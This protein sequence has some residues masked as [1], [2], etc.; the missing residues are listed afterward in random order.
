[1]SNP[2][3]PQAES[4]AATP[5]PL[6]RVFVIG[7]NRIVEDTSTVK[8]SNEQI[9]S[10]L[11]AQYPEIANATVRETVEGE[12]RVIAYLPIPGRKG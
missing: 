4:A 7:N 8:L 6:K 11:K 12:V 10:L 2:N 1:M 9:R 5:A 3:K